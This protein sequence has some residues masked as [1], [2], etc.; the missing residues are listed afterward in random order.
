MHIHHTLNF[1]MTYEYYER[2][3]LL[4]LFSCNKA[5]TL[6]VLKK[7]TRNGKNHNKSWSQLKSYLIEYH[8]QQR[9]FSEKK[10]KYY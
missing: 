10:K 6:F 7:T 1:V 9:T 5:F 3:Y 2:V 4:T 8:L